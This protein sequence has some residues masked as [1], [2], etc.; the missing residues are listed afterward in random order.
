MPETETEKGGSVLM[1][2]RISRYK[3][4]SMTNILDWILNR[5]FVFVLCQHP[6]K[7]PKALLWEAIKKSGGTLACDSGRLIM[8]AL[9]SVSFN[10]SGPAALV[11]I[12][13][14]VQRRIYCMDSALEKQCAA[15]LPRL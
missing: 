9:T 6:F 4:P 2:I 5:T 11:F 7:A 13:V 8:V 10:E 3:P 1:L 14:R 15:L 12:M